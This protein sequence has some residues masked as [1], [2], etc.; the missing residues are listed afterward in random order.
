[1]DLTR[2]GFLRL[3]DD[4]VDITVRPTGFPPAD[5]LLDLMQAGS[6]RPLQSWF[7]EEAFGLTQMIPGM[8]GAGAWCESRSTILRL[9]RYVVENERQLAYDKQLNPSM[10]RVAWKSDDAAVAAL[11]ALANLLGVAR[12]RSL[13]VPPPDIPEDVVAAMGDDR[14]ILEAS[15]EY[16]RIARAHYSLGAST[17]GAGGSL[18]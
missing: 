2:T 13:K 6:E 18:H 4:S 12:E 15:I 5:Q 16:L 17:L 7:T 10:R 14:W 8:V 1:V 9:R 11:G 3:T